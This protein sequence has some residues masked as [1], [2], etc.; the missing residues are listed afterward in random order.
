MTSRYTRQEQ[1]AG[2]QQASLQ[3][4]TVIVVGVG[5]LGN[6]VA[7]LL[8]LSGVGK[9]LLCDPD[10]V[11]L[12][13]LHRCGLFTEQDVGSLKVEAAARSLQRLVPGIQIECRAVPLIHGVGLAELRDADLVVSCLDSRAARLQLA[14]RCNLVNAP[15][16]D[17][18]TDAW[19]GEIRLFLEPA[20]GACYGCGL[21]DEA[22]SESDMPWSCQDVAPALPNSATAASSVLIASWMSLLAV[23]FLMG[24]DTP[25]EH[26]LVDAAQGTTR[27]VSQQRDPDCPL[28]MAIGEVSKIPL[29]H[30]ATLT[31]WRK[32]L[33]TEAT[34]LA[35][36][37]VQNRVDCPQCGYQ[38]IAWKLPEPQECPQCSAAMHIHTTLELAAAP[39]TITLAQLGVAP[40]EILAVR[41]AEGIGWFELSG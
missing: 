24:L 6:E 19:G 29:S 36:S 33:G 31:K 32:L 21:G 15:C 30:Q 28:H 5:A 10:Q 16:I 40:R 17:G 23:R 22:R 2:W 25:R 1:I 37:P 20:S 39:A 18:G 11:E 41:G 38:E 35:W 34:P 27:R 4:A 7:R 13:N 26:I 3:Q 8:A 12:S 14:G 9:L